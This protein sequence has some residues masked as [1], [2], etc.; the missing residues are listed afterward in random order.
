MPIF[1][2]AEALEKRKIEP[3]WWHYGRRC[4]PRILIVTDG[5]L[6]FEMADAFGLGRFVHAIAHHSSATLKPRLTLAH[7]GGHVPSVTISG[8][9]YSVASGFDFDTA[10][11]AVNRTNYDQIWLFGISQ[12]PISDAEVQTLAE[13]MNNRG[14][15]FATGDHTNLGAGMSARLPRIRHMR[16]WNTAT[17]GGVPMGRE[18][19]PT[20]LERIDTMVD[21]GA[22]ELYQF[23]DQSDDIPQRIYPNYAVTGTNRFDWVATIHPILRMPGM[24][25]S[26]GPQDAGFG[27]GGG[28]NIGAPSFSNDIDVLPDH[29]HESECFEVSDDENTAAFNGTYA[30][31]SLSFDEFPMASNGSGRVPAEIAAFS[32]SGGRTIQNGTWKPPVRPRMFGAISTFDGRKAQSSGSRQP[33]RIVCDATWHHFVNINLDGMGS[34]RDGLGS[35]SGGTFTPSAD[36]LKIYK[37]YQNMVAWL[38]PSN[39]IWCLYYI[40][41]AK[42]CYLHPMREELMEFEKIESDDDIRALGQ[43]MMGAI[44]AVYGAGASRDLVAASLNEV[45]K[46]PRLAVM[47][48]VHEDVLSPAEIDHVV[49]EI[50]GHAAADVVPHLPNPTV[51]AEDDKDADEA[52]ERLHKRFESEFPERLVKVAEAALTA[53]VKRRAEAHKQRQE[54]LARFR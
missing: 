6:N 30:E 9:T 54:K 32:V 31:A 20:S 50:I 37:Y 16:N 33:G 46:E 11:P 26:R 7:R 47:L 38:Q 8:T 15:V 1:L 43:T 13:F 29:P 17:A 40:Y 25:L 12:S 48:D 22:N 51:I 23:N 36:L 45:E 14:G 42:A 35:W 41:M 19:L 27:Q 3:H 2:E 28:L 21:P 34:G 10:T 49:A 4:K 39:R 52:E 18:D 44:D 53:Q 24:R 5:G